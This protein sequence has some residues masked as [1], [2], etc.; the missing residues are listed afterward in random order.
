MHAILDN[1]PLPAARPANARRHRIA[2]FEFGREQWLDARQAEIALR[3]HVAMRGAE[4]Y[5]SSSPSA[6]FRV[7]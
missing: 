7:H 6:L 1:L 4:S 2:G 5:L 3:A